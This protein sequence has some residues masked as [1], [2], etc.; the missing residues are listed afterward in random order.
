MQGEN[1]MEYNKEDALKTAK[2]MMEQGIDHKIIRDATRLREK[3]LRRIE[4]GMKEKINK[5]I[6]E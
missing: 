1:A 5:N 3:D 2:L 4:S 6:F